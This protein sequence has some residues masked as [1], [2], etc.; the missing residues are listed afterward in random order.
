MW[1]K[2][3][4]RGKQDTET[5]EGQH[6]TVTWCRTWADLQSEEV[7]ERRRTTMPCLVAYLRLNCV[8]LGLRIRYR[9][10][11]VCVSVPYFLVRCRLPAMYARA[12]FV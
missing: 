1:Y 2:S 7:C 3:G 4:R 8:S 6:I 12:F 10:P 11:E 5:K 9:D